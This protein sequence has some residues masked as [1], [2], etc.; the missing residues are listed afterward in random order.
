MPEWVS[1]HQIPGVWR[2]GRRDEAD[3][4]DLL[5]LMRDIG[6]LA[7]KYQ[8]VLLVGLGLAREGGGVTDLKHRC[9]ALR[10][11]RW[12]A[13]DVRFKPDCVRCGS[14]SG[15][16]LGGG[17]LPEMTRS[18]RTHVSRE[19]RLSGHSGSRRRRADGPE[20]VVTEP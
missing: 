7:P 20:L 17:G 12:R 18:G 9:S 2:L 1:A 10:A 8:D 19:L 3:T 15:R 5:V 13:A 11:R 6:P 14:G 16:S 4:P